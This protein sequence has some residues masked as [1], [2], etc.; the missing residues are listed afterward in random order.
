MTE[1]NR[2]EYEA[3]VLASLLHDVG[4]FFERG[5]LLDEYRKDEIQQQNDCP[6][7]P[8]R[9][10]YTHKHVLNTRAF[11]DVLAR[12]VPWLLPEPVADREKSDQNW[13]NLAARHHVATSALEKIIEKADHLSS[14]EREKGDFYTRSIHKKTRLEPVIERVFLRKNSKAQPEHRFELRALSLE[15]KSVFPKAANALNP[16]VHI[17]INAENISKHDWNHLLAK[18]HLEA[19]YQSL[20]NAMLEELKQLPGDLSFYSLIE[21]LLSLFEKYLSSVPAATNIRHTDISLYD[22]L[23]TT[24]AIADGLYRYEADKGVMVEEKWVLVCGDFS[25]IQTFIY[26]ITSKGAAKALRGRSLFVQILCD[27]SVDY[28]LRYVGGYSTSRLYS[29]GGKFYLLLSATCCQAVCDA[30]ERINEYLLYEFGGEVFLGVGIAPI[31]AKHFEQGEMSSRWKAVND[32]LMGNRK[33]RFASQIKKQEGFFDPPTVFS[34]KG[35]CKT[36]GRDD[37]AITEVAEGNRQIC[38]VCRQLEDLGAHLKDA[39]Y[40]LWS[41]NSSISKT[42]ASKLGR[43]PDLSLSKL[44]IQFFFMEDLSKLTGC[45]DFS[46]CRIERINSTDFIHGLNAGSGFRFVGH[47]D[48]GKL[49]GNWEFDKFADK[50]EGVNRIGILRMDVDNLGQVFIKGLQFP[51]RGSGGWGPVQK[52][53]DGSIRR[54]DMA[55]ISRVATLSRQLNLF[56]SGYLGELLKEY[57]RC[58]I[59][60]AGGDD[61]FVIGSWDQLPDLAQKIREAFGVFCCGNPDLTLSGGIA[62]TGGKYPVSRG[63]DHAGAAEESAKRYRS[64]KDSFCFFGEPLSWSDFIMAKYLNELFREIVKE[65]NKGFL[66][67]LRNIVASNKALERERRRKGMDMSKLQKLLAYDNWRW[68]V[69]YSLKRYV[70]QGEGI[71]QK[72]STV[73]EALFKDSVNGT[74]TERPVI[75]W[76]GLPTRW[77]EFLERKEK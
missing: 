43:K 46:E 25:G 60:Y 42:L 57:E 4:K 7:D 13:I 14:S 70:R 29:S 65:K 50:S 44:G 38:K 8:K 20:G 62:L 31:T 59:V 27:A 72:V 48:S 36:C 17:Q 32:D 34:P 67:R 75:T 66:D 15:K 68:Q 2:K 49:S 9:G 10:Y 63:A 24:A 58:Q 30:V 74:T 52:D 37:I 47:W 1:Y 28:I 76:I 55:S 5:E 39:R 23:R 40:F 3:I 64:E 33:N 12:Q 73:Q 35:G 21:T 53:L 71:K 6:K 77:A 61:L 18:E 11:C 41:F 45:T 56:F 16:P 19:V 69:A 54:K 22:H 51:D 26:R